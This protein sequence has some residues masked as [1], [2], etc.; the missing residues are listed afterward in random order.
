MRTGDTNEVAAIAGE[1]VE[2]RPGDQDDAYSAC[3]FWGTTNEVPYLMLTVHWSG[4]REQWEIQEAAYGLATGL[5][6]ASEDVDLDA[7]V[8]PGPVRGLGDA[9]VFAELLPSR[10]LSGDTML[11]IYV[12]YLPDAARHFRPRAQMILDRL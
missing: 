1:L 8:Q 6:S 2:A 10:V 5:F 4:G 3:E 12:F 9:A 11:E 7:V